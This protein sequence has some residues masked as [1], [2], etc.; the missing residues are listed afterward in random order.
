MDIEN[1]AFYDRLAAS[2][3]LIFENW[4]DTIERQAAIISRLLAPPFAGPVLDCACGIGT[5]VLGL[6]TLGF[7]IEGSDISPV[8]VARASTEA[9]S[10]KL[11]ADFRVDDMRMLRTA[12]MGRYAAVL[13][14]DNALPHLDSDEDIQKAITAMRDR[15]QPAGQL[16]I[17][18]RDY[19][20]LMSEHPST[21]PPRMFGDNGKRRIVHQ[22]WDWRDQRRYVLHLFITMKPQEQEWLTRHF[23]A[24]YRAVTP[25]EVARLA[26]QSGFRH[27]KVLD[28]TA[29]GYY[30]PIVCA[31]R[32]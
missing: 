23:V 7:S 11:T 10:R 1:A 18:L 32:E 2:Y 26:E 16:L 13:A 24:R 8:Q 29:T 4:Q 5:Q 15:L 21:M 20:P 9:A 25:D 12:P 22:V 28:P 17:S 3:H 30:Q 14:F 27:V 6:A 19:G 31:T